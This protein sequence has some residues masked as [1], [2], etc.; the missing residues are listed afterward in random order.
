M[1]T[2]EFIIVILAVLAAVGIGV[3]TWFVLK[4]KR[5]TSRLQSANENA[6][7][8]I[9]NAEDEGRRMLLAT[10]EEVLKLRNA[11]ETEIQEERQKLTRVE[12]RHMQREEQLESKI[13]AHE[14]R[15]GDLANKEND[16][17]EARKEVEELKGEHTKALERVA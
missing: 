5:N 1:I 14:L 9:T 13:E 10:H 6:A 16:V 8:V 7:D 17:A 12:S 4:S 11:A 15:L 2:V 3:S